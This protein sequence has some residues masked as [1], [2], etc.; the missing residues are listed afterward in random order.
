VIL[1]EAVDSRDLDIVEVEVWSLLHRAR[2]CLGGGIHLRRTAERVEVSG[3]LPTEDRKN[4]LLALLLGV[5]RQDL[6]RVDLRNVAEVPPAGGTPVEHRGTVPSEAP[7]EAWLRAHMRVGDAATQ[8]EMFDVMN[9]IVTNAGGLMAESWALRRLA[10]RYPVEAERDLPETARIELR[11]IA[12]DHAMAADSS[13]AAIAELLRP[14]GISLP[15]RRPSMSGAGD[16]QSAA[17]ALQGR[18]AQDAG[19]LLSLFTAGSDRRPTGAEAESE[20]VRAAAGLAHIREI[21]AQGREASSPSVR[22][23]VNRP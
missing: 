16:W 21:A 4:Q 17:L 2:L 5:G 1:R 19:V 10:E 3:L 11:V 13:I 9:A 20:V 7:A 12:E 8:R 18:A 23:A 14:L 6:L 22:G 15:P